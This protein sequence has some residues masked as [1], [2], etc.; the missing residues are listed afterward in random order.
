M[1]ANSG[2]IQFA[3]NSEKRFEFAIQRSPT[4]SSCGDR[5]QPRSIAFWVPHGVESA[6]SRVPLRAESTPGGCNRLV[7][8]SCKRDTRALPA[9]EAAKMVCAQMLQTECNVAHTPGG[10]DRLC[11]HPVKQTPERCPHTKQLRWSMSACCK[12]PPQSCPHMAHVAERCGAD[13]LGKPAHLHNLVQGVLHVLLGPRH[14]SLQQLFDRSAQG[15][16]LT[17]RAGAGGMVAAGLGKAGG[18]VRGTGIR[19]TSRC[20]ETSVPQSGSGESAASSQSIRRQA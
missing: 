9:H 12:Q 20:R 14:I 10:C 1:N 17:L 19:I 8:A 6:C 11:A 13:A 18:H 16:T 5:E 2:R 15:Q 3:V 4:V 7:C